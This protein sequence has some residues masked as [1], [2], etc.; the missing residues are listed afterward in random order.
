MIDYKI[1]KN[2]D[3]V[4]LFENSIIVRISSDCVSDDEYFELAQYSQTN[5]K[6]ELL[7][8]LENGKPLVQL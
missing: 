5:L 6:K 4:R 1:I 8:R 7:E 3:L 2:D